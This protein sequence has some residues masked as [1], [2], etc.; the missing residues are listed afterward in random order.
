LAQERERF[1]RRIRDDAGSGVGGASLDTDFLDA[2]DRFAALLYERSA[3]LSLIG[4]SDRGQIYSRHL[5]DSLNPLSFF[6]QPPDRILDIGS[7]GGLPGVP[8]ALAWPATKVVLLESRERKAAFLERA[9]RTLGLRSVRVV[10]ERLEEHVRKTGPDYDALF[11]RAVA[12]PARLVEAASSCC[13]PGARWVYFLG[14][15]VDLDGLRSEFEAAGREAAPVSGLFGGML[16]S[17]RV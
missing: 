15:G 13:T 14:A 1:R 12:E 4:K 2:I 16:L 5:L 17:G 9:A 11:I 3:A 8:L 7:G 10:C 6:D